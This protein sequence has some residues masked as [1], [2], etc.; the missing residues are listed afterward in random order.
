VEKVKNEY[1]DKLNDVNAD[2]VM[3]KIHSAKNSQEIEQL[4]QENEL[5]QQEIKSAEKIAEAEK[6]EWAFAQFAQ[7]QKQVFSD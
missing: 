7:S 1:E 2:V 6:Q 5:I 3:A 4:K